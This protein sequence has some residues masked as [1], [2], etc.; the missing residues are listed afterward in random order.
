MEVKEVS[1]DTNTYSALTDGN[2]HI[3]SLL[4]SV[5]RLIFPFIVIAELLAGFRNG[6]R[7]KRNREQLFQ[8]LASNTSDIIYADMQTSEHYASIFAKLRGKGR[9][10][11]TNDMW[12]AAIALQHGLPLCTL[13]SDFDH[14]DGLTII[15]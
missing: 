2:A 3:T 15:R 7:E 12:I 5:D 9:M 13:D 11:P 1:I 14:V 4:S 8:L 10:I 6:S